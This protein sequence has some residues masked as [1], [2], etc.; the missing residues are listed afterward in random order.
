MT[1]ILNGINL[2]I[3]S[4]CFRNFTNE[5]I[6]AL[7]KECGVGALE[8]CRKHLDVLAEDIPADTVLEHY[9]SQGIML[10]SY[11]INTYDNNE[12][13]T[14]KF[15]EFAAKAGISI[16]G[17]KPKPESFELLEKLCEEYSIKLAIHN[18][19]RKDDMYGSVD[20]LREALSRT[21]S[22]IGLCV[23]TGWFLDVG[24]D[25][26]AVIR[27]FPDRIHG[28]HFKDFIY[29]DDGSRTE[30]VIGDGSLDVLGVLKELK[31]IGF[32]GYASIEFEGEPENPVPSIQ[33][34]IAR[35]KE[36]EAQL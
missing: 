24:V 5:E 14:R 21:S 34:C 31:R 32:N 33:Q 8:I 35:L 15:F 10:N 2:G 16:L 20:K 6:P 29:G 13:K 12:T 30:A 27:E 18:H 28:I 11:G 22:S 7:L 17:A 25:P 23:D 19:G 36:A 9:R 4:W 3:Q 1:T 26:L